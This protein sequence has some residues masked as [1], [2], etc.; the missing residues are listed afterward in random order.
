MSYEGAVDVF[1]SW[2]GDRSKVAA[3]TLRE[4]LPKVLQAARP[5]MSSEDIDKGARWSKELSQRLNEC[6]Y[7]IICVTA[8]NRDTAWLN[9]EAGALSKVVDSARVAPLLI[10][11]NKSDVTGPLAHLQLTDIDHN[12]VLLL[13]QSMNRALGENAV[14]SDLLG[15]IF[16]R[17]WP[18][19]ADQLEALAAAELSEHGRDTRTDRELLEEMLNMVRSHD[20]QL[21]YLVDNCEFGSERSYQSV[22]LGGHD[23][24]GVVDLMAA[25]EESVREAR[26]ARGTERGPD[27]EPP[28][29]S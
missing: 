3:A 28:A 8:E 4:W 7:G 18:D 9:F 24:E 6:S 16:D 5:W 21:D 13:I 26:R 10:G 17:W 27:N 1:L 22:A 14:R 20:S 25:L 15:E 11:L 12:D 2:S 29:A 23:P 19:L